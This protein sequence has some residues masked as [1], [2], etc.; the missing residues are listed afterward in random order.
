MINI[1]EFLGLGYYQSGL[2]IFLHEFDKENPGL[3]ESQRK[4][5][6]K[7]TRIYSLRDN[8]GGKLL[9]SDFWENF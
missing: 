6:E 5:I 2:D 1:R 4:E 7:Y 9:S 3:S 8:P